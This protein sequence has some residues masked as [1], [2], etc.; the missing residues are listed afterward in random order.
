MGMKT[1]KADGCTLPLPL[2]VPELNLP[3]KA[4]A[5]G[6]AKRFRSFIETG[7][8]E[9]VVDRLEKPVDI[10]CWAAVAAYI[11]ALLPVCVRLVAR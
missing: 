8:W 4:Q 10:L 5:D 2:E 3:S 1:V 7:D 9:G 11:L 6:A